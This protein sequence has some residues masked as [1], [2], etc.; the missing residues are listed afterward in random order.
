MSNANKDIPSNDKHRRLLDMLH[1]WA[2]SLDRHA[3]HDEAEEIADLYQR[4]GQLDIDDTG[5]F[6]SGEETDKLIK[7][8]LINEVLPVILGQNK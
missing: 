8:F 6:W 3:A 5:A 4:A 7:E 1:G 2:D